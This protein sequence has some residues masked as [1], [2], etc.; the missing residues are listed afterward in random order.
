MASN[1]GMKGKKKTKIRTPTKPI[2]VDESPAK[3]PIKPIYSNTNHNTGLN[4][5]HTYRE[6]FHLIKRRTSITRY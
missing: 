1:E 5:P 2:S 4:H 3:E 6:L